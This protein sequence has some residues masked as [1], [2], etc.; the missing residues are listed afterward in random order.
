MP[1]FTSTLFQ[2][3]PNIL[4]IPLEKNTIGLNININLIHICLFKASGQMLVVNYVS[5]ALNSF[6]FG[7]YQNVVV[8]TSHNKTE[9]KGWVYW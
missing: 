5:L 1:N 7:R 8:E 6:V 3:G 4:S 9:S 2:H